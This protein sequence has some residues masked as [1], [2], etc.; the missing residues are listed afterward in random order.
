M[1][2]WPFNVAAQLS[3]PSPPEAREEVTCG[4]LPGDRRRPRP[5]LQGR[6]DG[7]GAC[8]QGI[9]KEQGKRALESVAATVTRN[10]STVSHA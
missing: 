10:A 9:G 7:R 8:L 4:R 6:L 5:A 2:Y 1:G 3:W